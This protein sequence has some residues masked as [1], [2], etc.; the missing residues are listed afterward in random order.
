MSVN[1]VSGVT[2]PIAQVN[3]TQ[4][5]AQRDSDGDYD[6]SKPGEVEAASEQSSPTSTS[7]SSGSLV[8]TKA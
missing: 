6:G 2:P 1:N 5:K 8:N 4:V 3:T 7:V